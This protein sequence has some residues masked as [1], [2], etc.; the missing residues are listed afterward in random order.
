V[1]FGSF[2]PLGLAVMVFAAVLL[3]GGAGLGFWLLLRPPAHPPATEP[4]ST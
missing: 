2:P 1:R 4:P 3:F